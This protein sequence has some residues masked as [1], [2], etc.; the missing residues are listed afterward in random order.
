MG[1]SEGLGGN[2]QLSG[3][4]KVD[5]RGEGDQVIEKGDQAAKNKSDLFKHSIITGDVYE[6][7]QT[8]LGIK[9][10]QSKQRSML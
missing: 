7:P 5:G 4:N 9:K 1:N 6:P 2:H 3:V 8:Q 10:S